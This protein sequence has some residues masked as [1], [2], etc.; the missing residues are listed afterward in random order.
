[1]TPE[2]L[3]ALQE[4]DPQDRFKD[5]VEQFQ[6]DFTDRE[7]V[8]EREQLTKL[9]DTYVKSIESLNGKMGWKKVREEAGL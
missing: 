1:M 4:D 8:K 5:Q 6:R 9:Y 2:V 7:F 3:A